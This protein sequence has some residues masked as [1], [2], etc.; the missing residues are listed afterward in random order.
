MIT[1]TTTTAAATMKIVRRRG[2]FEK[3]C[4]DDQPA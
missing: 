1:A 4:T 3:S 2:T